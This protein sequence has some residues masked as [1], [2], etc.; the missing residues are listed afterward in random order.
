M[1]AVLL[2]AYSI[3]DMRQRGID[4]EQQMKTQSLNCEG[5]ADYWQDGQEVL[6]FIQKVCI[7]P[8]AFI[9]TPFVPLI[10]FLD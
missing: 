7:Q 9:S 5:S 3:R 6:S 4:I 10:L 8:D 1:D 2:L